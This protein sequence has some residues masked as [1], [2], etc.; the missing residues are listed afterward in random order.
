MKENQLNNPSTSSRY[1][2]INLLTPA[3]SCPTWSLFCLDYYD[4]PLPCLFPEGGF[5]SQLLPK[6]KYALVFSRPESFRCLPRAR[7]INS[8]L[9]SRA[10]GTCPTSAGPPFPHPSSTLLCFRCPASQHFLNA[11]C[12]ARL[13]ALLLL[14]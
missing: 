14:L 5:D 6:T 3:T 7:A 12:L 8:H 11:I 1:V 4:T 2:S 10:F 9:L 13:P